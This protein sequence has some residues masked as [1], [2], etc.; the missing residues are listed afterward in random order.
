MPRFC[1]GHGQQEESR[2]ESWWIRIIVRR[3]MVDREEC[4][5]V[6]EA[7]AVYRNRNTSRRVAEDG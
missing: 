7:L 6:E 1:Q 4:R 2:G 3:V 5:V